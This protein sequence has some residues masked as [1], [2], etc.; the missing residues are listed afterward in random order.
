[1]KFITSMSGAAI[2]LCL[3]LVGLAGFIAYKHRE[4][5]GFFWGGLAVFLVG[6]I[7][8]VKMLDS[9]SRPN[10]AVAAPVV[11]AVPAPVVV[12]P[13]APVAAVPITPA[14]LPGVAA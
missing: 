14:P 6:S 4:K 10:M 9:G 12:A 1:M 13:P 7:L 11:G 8:V 5:E 2:F 3:M